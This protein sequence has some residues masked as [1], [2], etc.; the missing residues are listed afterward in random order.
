MAAE[1]KNP[2]S[3]EPAT[4]LNRR[5]SLSLNT[6][7]LFEK[8]ASYQLRQTE[9]HWSLCSIDRNSEYAPRSCKVQQHETFISGTKADMKYQVSSHACI[10]RR[11]SP[12]VNKE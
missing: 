12:L 9:P 3:M 10:V 1:V 7:H 8:A 6:M 11:L 2:Y 4:S 5:H